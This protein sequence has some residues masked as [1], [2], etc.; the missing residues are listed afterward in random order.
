MRIAVAATPA[1]AIPSLEALMQRHEIVA[2]FTQPDKPYGRGQRLRQSDVG[3]W[4]QSKGLPVFKELTHPEILSAVDLVITVAYGVLVRDELLKLPR[5]GFINLHYS[6]LPR[7]RGAAPVQRA[8]L[9]GD[10]ETGVTIFKLDQGM[11]TGPIY[12]QRRLAIAPTWNS[13]ELF[14]ELN[15]LGSS[16]LLDALDEIEQGRVP[17]EQEGAATLAPKIDKSEFH[18][19]FY[20]PAL[21]VHN[22]IRALFPHSY[23]LVQ[24]ERVKALTS[25]EGEGC[26]APAGSVIEQDPLTIACGD[27]R[28][29]II[30]RVVPEGKREMASGDWLRGARL[31]IGALVG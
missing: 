6:L 31:E 17:R 30:E 9:A 18:L 15:V 26:Q 16:A 19:D 21:E 4:A 3:T 8:L 10:S 13:A 25:R 24:G 7:W 5:H 12:I 11:D 29:L 23:F 27:G 14:D 22:R 2:V 20:R 28:A 1:I